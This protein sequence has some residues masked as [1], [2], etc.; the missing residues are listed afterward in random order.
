MP[1]PIHAAGRAIAKLAEL[2][3]PSSPKTTFN[4]GVVSGGTSV[5]SIPMEGVFE[6]DMRSESAEALQTIDRQAR[7]AID[8]ALAEELAR[9]PESKKPL[10]VE[11][12][13]IG[14]RPA[15]SRQPDTAPIV[16][17]A[18][19]AA[20]AVGK[21]ITE[22]RASSTDANVPLGLGLSAITVGGGGAGTGAHGSEEKYEDGPEGFKGPQFVALL[23]A[24]LAGLRR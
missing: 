24:T 16:R 12:D 14:I 17:A 19:A 8:A 20:R 1:N 13:T 2:R 21:P 18:L 4:V 3:V 7:A 11:I 10:A 23:V 5:N 22:T 6:L 9:W 15:D